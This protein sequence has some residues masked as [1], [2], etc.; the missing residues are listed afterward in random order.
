MNH[1]AAILAYLQEQL[2][3]SPSVK[4]G[5]QVQP[6][7]FVNNPSLMQLALGSQGLLR[8]GSGTEIIITKMPIILLSLHMLLS[9]ALCPKC[10]HLHS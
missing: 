4:G 9:G 10:S 1:L 8:H 6:K 7:L 2:N 3:P 5:L